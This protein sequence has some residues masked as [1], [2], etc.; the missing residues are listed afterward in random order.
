MKRG[1]RNGKNNSNWTN[2]NGNSKYGSYHARSYKNE[3]Y[4]SRNCAGSIAGNLGHV[5]GAK[6]EYPYPE[7]P[8]GAP[9]WTYPYMFN[10]CTLGHDDREETLAERIAA[11]CLSHGF[12][13]FDEENEKMVPDIAR[14]WRYINAF[15]ARWDYSFAYQT[16]W[17]Y[18]NRVCSPKIDR[19]NLMAQAMNVTPQWLMGYG[20]RKRQVEAVPHFEIIA[21]IDE[22]RK[23]SIAARV[24]KA[25]ET[26][27][28]KKAAIS[29]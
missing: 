10:R 23:T 21:K 19:V 7:M 26:R 18:F 13:K 9:Y 12:S 25:K 14:F 11:W 8:Y 20:E 6:A 27:A 29:A 3:S 4:K 2:S 15:A 16:I 5:D 17:E 24:A 28:K 1:T 22:E